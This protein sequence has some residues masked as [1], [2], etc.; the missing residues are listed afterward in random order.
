MAIEAI[1]FILSLKTL[2]I[3]RPDKTGLDCIRHVRP[4]FTHR[5][6]ERKQTKN[7]PEPSSGVSCLEVP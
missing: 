2:R 7:R 1:P 5:R 6:S 3:N 4:P